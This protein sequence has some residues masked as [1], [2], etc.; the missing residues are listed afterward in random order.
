MDDMA[1]ML[2]SYA[3]GLQQSFE[4]VF[5]RVGQSLTQS[6]QVMR[7]MNEVMESAM[8]QNLS[9]S[10]GYDLHSGLII[11]VVNSSQI[12]L[13]QTKV[14]ARMNNSDDTFF[15]TTLDSLRAGGRVRLQAALPDVV[16]PVAGF[17]ELECI[18]P[19]TQQ[20]LTKRLTFR[21]FFFQQGTFQALRRGEEEGTPGPSEV[22]VTSDRFLLTRV[23]ELLDLSPIRGI[24][25]DNEGRYR[26]NPATSS[27]D[28]TVFYL[29]VSE[30]TPAGAAFP[31]TVSAAGSANTV[32]ARRRQCQQIIDDMEIETESSDEDY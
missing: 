3:G 7:M 29:S 26:F 32:E 21:V 1:R 18:S 22:A 4:S 24:L 14:S 20:P 15:S 27:D 31:V 13:G 19:G 23:R 8:L 5:E 10:S 25:T 6:A 2:E 12:M 17:I 11:E 16:G 28:D 30:G 9:I